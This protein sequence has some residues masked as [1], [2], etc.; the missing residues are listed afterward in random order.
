MLMDSHILTFGQVKSKGK[1]I[2]LQA[3]WPLGFLVGLGSRI[4]RHSAHE[5]GKVV[6]LTHRPSL[7]AGKSWYSFLEAESTPRHVELSDAPEKIPSDR[8]SIPGPSNQQCSA[9][10]TTPPQVPFG[11]VIKDILWVGQRSRYNGWLRAGRS[12][13]RIPVGGEIF[14]SRRDQPWGPPSLLYNRYWVFPRGKATRAWLDHPPHLA[15]RL[16]KEQSYTSSP[17]L[18][19]RGLCKGELYLYLLCIHVR[20]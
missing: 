11:Q 13:H 17:P 4:S 1:V 2:P 5:G 3:Q 12:G 15:P 18:S 19:L 14:H 8:G 9:L 16:K 10:T 6:T 7:P 20:S